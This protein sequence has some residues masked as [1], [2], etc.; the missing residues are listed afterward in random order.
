MAAESQIEP[1]RGRTPSSIESTPSP[2]PD[3]GGGEPSQEP[4]QPQKRKG[5]RKP[6]NANRSSNVQVYYNANIGRYTQLLKNGN[7][8]IDKHRQPFENDDPNTSNNL[9]LLSNRMKSHSQHYNRAIA[10]LL[11]NVLCSVT[12][13]RCWNGSCLRK[14]IHTVEIRVRIRAR[15]NT[16]QALTSKQ[17]FQ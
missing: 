13:I 6:V 11:T 5:G 7:N 4:V 2:E 12:R 17:N 16:L 1:P 14:V 3:A 10:L 8:G 15:A 9:R